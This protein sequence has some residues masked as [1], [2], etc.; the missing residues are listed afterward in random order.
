M[1]KKTFNLI[2]VLIV[3]SLVSSCSNKKYDELSFREVK[4]SSSAQLWW[5]RNHADINKDGI[6]DLV[7]INN[8]GAGGWLGWLEGTTDT[9]KEWAVHIIKDSLED[10]RKF[11]AGDLEVADFDNDGDVDIIGVVH[12]G[13]WVDAAAE[14]EIFWYE[15]PSWEEH[16]IG[17][18]PNALKDINV[19]DLNNDNMIDVVT[20]NFEE[21]YLTIFYQ[22]EDG[23]FIIGW[24]EQIKNLHE[25]MDLADLDGDSYNDIAANG[26]WLRN[27]GKDATK[28]WE[29]FVI[30]TIWNN[31]T[32]DWSRNAT[33]IAC[34]DF[35][36]DGKS[37]VIIGHSERDGYPVAIY[38]LVDAGANKWKKDILLENLTAAHNL[39]VEDFDLDGEPEILTGVNK[40]RAMNIN[41]NDSPVLIL[42]Q[43]NS[44]WEQL[45]ISDDGIYNAQTV[46]F[47]G[48]GDVDIFRYPTHDVTDFYL[49]I[50]K[51]IP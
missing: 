27:P 43:K 12:P 15:N 42:D 28:N 45:K 4:I 3:F 35:D 32:G 34:Y 1:V 2:L 7:L 19:S 46:D 29:V 49:M 14:A 47:D 39:R 36:K 22:Q 6:T 50:N 17:V 41:V 24:Q 33:K 13:E 37:E 9:T 44:K 30:D 20:M 23:S 25:G 18:I 26:Y 31:Q 11:A 21:N 51:V 5:A 16:S 38:S 8:N 40:H 10:G 48:D